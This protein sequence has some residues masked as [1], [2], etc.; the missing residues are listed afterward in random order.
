MFKFLK[1][2][3]QAPAKITQLND[4][5]QSALPLL[6]ATSL[7]NIL[8]L[9]NRL[10]NIKRLTSLDQDTF[11]QLYEV[12]IYKF[13]EAAQL[14]PASASYHHTGPGGLIAHT[15]AV[16]E[17]ALEERMHHI[18]PELS[19][20]ETQAKEKHLWTYAIFAAALLHDAGKLLTQQTLILSDRSIFSPFA[21][22]NQDLNYSIMFNN[23]PE[24]Y[25][26]HKQIAA[27]FFGLLIPQKAQIWLSQPIHIFDEFT[28]F[29][30]G[31]DSNSIAKIIQRGDTKSVAENIGVK[32]SH[33]F[34]G[35]KPPLSEKLIIAIRQIM[36]TLGINKPG[37]AAFKKGNTVWILSKILGDS[38]K[39]WLKNHAESVPHDNNR[40]FDELEHYALKGS[41]GVVQ[42]IVIKM[43]GFE[44]RFSVVG[45]NVHKLYTSST[46]PDD[47]FG[48]IILDD[49]NNV[50]YKTPVTLLKSS[51]TDKPSHADSLSQIDKTDHTNK[52][53]GTESKNTG[54][55]IINPETEIKDTP[56]KPTLSEL[57]NAKTDN[58]WGLPTVNNSQTDVKTDAEA[59]TRTDA[60][61]GYQKTEAELVNPNKQDKHEDNLLSNPNTQTNETITEA[62]IYCNCLIICILS[63][64]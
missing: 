30:Q 31:N 10:R 28:G 11:A 47:L 49:D 62:D 32:N 14:I 2:H 5:N 25:R 38:V 39:D 50:S 59:D 40:I 46:L 41:K 1:K 19:D 9:H 51:H 3:N 13:I 43:T 56:L 54:T 17:Y 35:A 45:F 48:D 60:E 23:Y 20:V 36:P 21:D 18:L 26:I 15:V 37:A 16:V 6:D 44:Q 57:A 4:L 27:T 12:A 8:G 61:W 24:S 64:T 34:L 33:R 53:T 63:S 29:I 42:W 55:V 58:V 22:L 52:T 7:I